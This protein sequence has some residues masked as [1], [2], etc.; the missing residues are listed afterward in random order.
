MPVGDARR[1]ASLPGPRP[2]AEQRTPLLR[3]LPL[4]LGH[5]ALAAERLL[6]TDA[7]RAHADRGTPQVTRRRV[8]LRAALRRLAGQVLGLPP[9]AVPLRA[10]A[11]GRPELDVPGID[12][13]CSR[14][15]ELG[16]VAVSFGERLGI[17]VERIVPWH[18]DVLTEGWLSRAERTSLRA[19]DPT[20]RAIASARCWTRK[21]AVLKGMGSGLTA[22]MADLEAGT[23]EDPV[24]VGGWRLEALPV[25][26]GHIA[27]VATL[28]AGSAPGPLALSLAAPAAPERRPDG[29]DQ[30]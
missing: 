7:E 24:V 9:A 23:A 17:D 15:G 14:S 26:A 8:A 10:G 27:S 22:S 1:R 25:P 2:P 6:L 29:H 20:S 16:L 30:S 3:A 28:P 11:Y 4:D 13:G 12:V 5:R 21:E 18:D 19:L